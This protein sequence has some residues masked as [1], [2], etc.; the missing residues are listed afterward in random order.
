MAMKWLEGV[1]YGVGKLKSTSRDK[2]L[3]ITK[4]TVDELMLYH[5]APNCGTL[6]IRAVEM[7]NRFVKIAEDNQRLS[8]E[9]VD[10][11]KSV[12]GLQEKLLEAKNEQLSAV[13]STVSEKID[14]VSQEVKDYSAAVKSGNVMGGVPLSQSCLKPKAHNRCTTTHPKGIGRW[15]IS[16]CVCEWRGQG[17]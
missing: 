4:L 5:G 6:I 1:R 7:V 8:S 13:T 12:I 2:P 16:E 10:C 11:Q 17:T 9:L 14:V 15:Q 3:D